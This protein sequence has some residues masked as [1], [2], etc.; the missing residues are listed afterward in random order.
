MKLM[1]FW[2]ENRVVCVFYLNIQGR[3]SFFIAMKGIV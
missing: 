3:K 2:T 1:A